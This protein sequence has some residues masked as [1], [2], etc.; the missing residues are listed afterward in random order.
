MM[1][2][3]IIAVYTSMIKLWTLDKIWL[4]IKINWD[5]DQKE[6]NAR[7]RHK[8]ISYIT[9]LKRWSQRDDRM[10]SR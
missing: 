2:D 6:T 9:E 3:V 7:R 5:V 8:V 1:F 4:N 10:W